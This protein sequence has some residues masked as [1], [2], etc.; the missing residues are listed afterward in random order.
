[1]HILQYLWIKILLFHIAISFAIAHYGITDY[2]GAYFEGC[3]ELTKHSSR[4]IMADR[5][6]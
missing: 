5:M 4:S 1:M 3:D 6:N 2:S